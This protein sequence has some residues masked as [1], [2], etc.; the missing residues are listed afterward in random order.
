MTIKKIDVSQLQPGMFVTNFKTHWEKHPFYLRRLQIDSDEQIRLVAS[1]GIQEVFIDTSRGRDVAA[2]ATGAVSVS[3]GRSPS[4]EEFR[5]A[6]RIIEQAS[7]VVRRAFNDIRLGRKADMASMYQ[8]THEIA[9]SVIRDR[10]LMMLVCSMYQRRPSVFVHSVNVCVLLINFASQQQL[11]S[12]QLRALALGGLLHDLGLAPAGAASLEAGA[13]VDDHAHVAKALDLLKSYNLAPETL[14]AIGEHHERADGSGFPRGL[15]GGEISLYGSMTGIADTYDQLCSPKLCTP[16]Y[17]VDVLPPP[18]A[19]AKLFEWGPRYF[20]SALGAGFVR[21]IGI[22]P[23]GSLVRLESG[24]LAVVMQ[25]RPDALLHP[26]VRIIYDTKL[27]GP[28][29]AED[30]DLVEAPWSTQERIVAPEDPAKWGITLE[31]YL[32]LN[33]QQ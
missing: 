7:A 27:P 10:D 6:R 30:R 12:D 28:V 32:G 11:A 33:P 8:M 18:E 24:L 3:R 16:S 23:V 1:S 31:D 20:D 21:A 19:M 22:Y 13:A 17:G 5:Q 25:H 4:A 26:R 15:A 29:R 14:A 9:E 2:G